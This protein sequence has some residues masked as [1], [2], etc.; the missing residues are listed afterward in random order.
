M[1]FNL[2]FRNY[3][4]IKV[5][6]ETTGQIAVQIQAIKLIQKNHFHGVRDEIT[7]LL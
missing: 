2:P 3:A 7:N 5:Q 6:E 1:N 4:I